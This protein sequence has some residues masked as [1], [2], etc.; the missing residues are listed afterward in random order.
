MSEYYEYYEDYGDPEEEMSNKTWKW[1]KKY[2]ELKKHHSK[3]HYEYIKAQLFINA[4]N[5]SP[6]HIVLTDQETSEYYKN[7]VDALT[8]EVD[9]LAKMLAEGVKK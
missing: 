8:K 7:I 3:L 5:S 1:R 9:R 2:Y 6:T 4:S